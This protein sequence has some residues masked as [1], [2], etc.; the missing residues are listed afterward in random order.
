MDFVIFLKVLWRKMWIVASIPFIAG[1]AA[2]W[3]TR[4]FKEVYKATAQISTGYTLNDQ[5]RILDEKFNLKEADVKFSNLLNAMSS[6]LSVNLLS[7]RLLLHD[8]D[9]LQQPFHTPDP[10]TFVEFPGEAERVQQILHEKLAGLVPLS[11]FDPEFGLVQ[12]FLNA[13]G[14]SADDIKNNLEVSRIEETDFIEVAFKSD[15]PGLSAFA[16]NTFCEEFMRYYASL[17]TERTGESVEFLRRLMEEKKATLDD[18]LEMQKRFKASNNVLDIQ[19]ESGQDL[20]QIGTLELQRDAMLSEINRLELT[21]DRLRRDIDRAS[22]PN[23]TDNSEIL[24]IRQQIHLLNDRYISGGGKNKA[25]K[26]SINM[27]REKLAMLTEASGGGQKKI[28]QG[29]TLPEL[30]AKLKDA[31]IEYQV[32]KNNLEQIE[33]N[34]LDLRTNFSGY[35]S[36]E[37]RLAAIQKEID[38]ASQ[39]YLEAMEKYNLAKAH[40]SSSEGLRQILKALPPEKPESSVRLI[41]I[42]LATFTSMAIALFVIVA[43]ELLDNTIRTPLKFK[44]QVNLP[45]AGV[46]NHIDSRNFNIRTY[47]N[48]Q[49]GS[50]DSEIFKSLLRKFRHAIE[51]MDS[52]I[53]LFTSPNKGDGKTFVMFS[54]AYV[55]SLINKRILIIDTNFRNNSLS[56]LLCRDKQG[57]KV[58]DGFQRKLLTAAQ[59]RQKVKEEEEYDDENSYDLINPTKYKNIYVVGNSGEVSESPA[60]ILSGRDF[61][62]LILSLSESFDYILLEGAAMNEFSDTPELTNYAD[63]VIAIFSADSTIRQLDRDAIQYFKSLGKKFGGCVLNRVYSKDLKL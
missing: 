12:K 56:K 21:M 48:Q 62:N 41:I 25:L 22:I 51:C 37:A 30:E 55:L 24:D 20:A 6:G 2:F 52:K 31:E 45:L 40:H 29:F 49:N 47:F 50:R 27:L 4:D 42:G 38:M 54:L 61:A 11:K 63:K 36:K 10:E 15:K 17:K 14:Y 59:G 1:I 8:L 5:V 26:D 23:M 9:T 44:R 60:E 32:A 7:Y 3:F 46:I 43:Y 58:L 34:I 18:K 16:A 19:G 57:L 53:I 35:A 39:E 13:Y 28:P 33:A